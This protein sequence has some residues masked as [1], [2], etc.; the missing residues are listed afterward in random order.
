MH[1]FKIVL[2]VLYLLEI[3]GH[4]LLI[5]EER[6]RITPKSALVNLIVNATIVTGIIYYL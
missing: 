3:S 5:G 6:K 4:T 1:W 2:I